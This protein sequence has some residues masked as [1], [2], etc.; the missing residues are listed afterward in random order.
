M[1][2][3]VDDETKRLVRIRTAKKAQLGAL[4][5]QIANLGEHYA[6]P[7]MLV[8]RKALADEIQMV[9][10]AVTTP[11]RPFIGDELGASGRFLVYH[12]ENKRTN[13]GMVL[14]FARVEGLFE[15]M[16]LHRQWLVIIGGIVVVVL[17][18]V[19]IFVTYVLT[20]GGI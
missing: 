1:P 18:I 14:L 8:E 6:P 16:K 17:L 3:V 10:D 15:E 5:E 13:D 19:A 11:A 4:E 20:K 7:H 12:A 2:H 9:E